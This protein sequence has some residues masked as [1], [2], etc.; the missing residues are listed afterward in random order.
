M[1]CS[2]GDVNPWGCEEL[3][4][5]ALCSSYIICLRRTKAYDDPTQ[6]KS[7]PTMRATTLIA[8]VAAASGGLAQNVSVGGL[9]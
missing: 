1:T 3:C 5:V 6:P 7:R 2:P 8:A 9:K 4:K